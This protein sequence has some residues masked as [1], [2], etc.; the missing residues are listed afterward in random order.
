[1]YGQKSSIWTKNAKRDFRTALSMAGIPIAWWLVIGA[2][3]LIWGISLGFMDWTSLAAEPTFNGLNNFIL[4]FT[5][6][7]YLLALWRSFY[8]GVSS[9]ILTTL[10]GFFVALG[11]NSI[12]KG[13]GIL[14]TVWYV[15]VITSAVATTQIFNI[16]LD[17]FSGVINNIIMDAGGEPV[18]WMD[19]TG[20]AVCWILI[21]SAWKG[22]GGSALLWLAGLQSIDKSVLEA[23]RVDGANAWQRLVYV[24][25]P[26]LSRISLFI[27][28]TGFSGAMQ[29]YEQ[30]MFI[31]GGGPFGTTEVLAYKIMRDAFW[32]NNFGMAGASS[33]VMALVTFAFTIASFRLMAKDVK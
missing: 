3:P 28:V 25:I 2:F 30:V 9:F 33:L 29:I 24:S 17:P 27:F 26:Q 11:L 22:V 7:S 18:F 32:E 14:R 23:A 5:S 13:K 10:A 21:Y 4:F 12:T 20:W 6:P 1:M 16:F 8:I 31:S 19:S 15:P